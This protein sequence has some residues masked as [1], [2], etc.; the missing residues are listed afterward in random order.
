[1]SGVDSEER[2]LIAYVII[3]S[4]GGQRK[5]SYA[6]PHPIP[7]PVSPTSIPLACDVALQMTRNSDI[8]PGDRG[9]G[10]RG[11]TE[12]LHSVLPFVLY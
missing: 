11:Y 7:S 4:S 8:T 5:F 9:V 1:V 3:V 10:N 12:S 6:K 2:I